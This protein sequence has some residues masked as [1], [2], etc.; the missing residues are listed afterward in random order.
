M[1]NILFT[2]EKMY[3]MQETRRNYITWPKE[4]R[5]KCVFP[6]G[7]KCWKFNW[8]ALGIAMSLTRRLLSFCLWQY[9]RDCIP[10]KKLHTCYLVYVR[11]L[12]TSER[13]LLLLCSVFGVFLIKRTFTMRLKPELFWNL[14]RR[15][16]WLSLLLRT[17]IF[18]FLPLRTSEK[19]YYSLLNNWQI[20][21]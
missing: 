4:S 16:E 13:W 7:R 3:A 21:S 5:E 9:N 12:A 20:I 18:S 10:F 11:G 1:G 2:S 17:L 8:N 14:G 6:W 19:L 15:V